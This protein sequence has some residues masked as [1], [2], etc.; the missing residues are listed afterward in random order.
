MNATDGILIVALGLAGLIYWRIYQRNVQVQSA[1]Q[2]LGLPP[3]IGLMPLGQF[4]VQP[5]RQ[6]L[7]LPPGQH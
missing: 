7:L 4:S 1:P 3:G 6:W 5:D 2:S